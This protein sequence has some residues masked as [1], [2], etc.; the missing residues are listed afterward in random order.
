MPRTM[1][2]LFTLLITATM[3]LEAHARLESSDPPNASTVTTAPARVTLVFSESARLTSL[4]I[5]GPHATSSQ[6]LV[7]HLAE[8]QVRHVVPLPK[9]APGDYV[10][11]WRALSDDSHV[12]SG[13][14]KF[15]VRSDSLTRK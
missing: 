7:V 9:L 12:T 6:R 5:Q 3:T 11:T 10:L 2:L 8:D 14:V 4:A 1:P 15:S 13:T